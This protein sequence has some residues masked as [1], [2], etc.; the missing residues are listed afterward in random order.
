MLPLLNRPDPQVFCCF[1]RSVLGRQR[2]VRQCKEREKERYL[3]GD[4]RGAARGSRDPVRAR[5]NSRE[6]LQRPLIACRTL[7]KL[8]NLSESSFHICIVRGIPRACSVDQSTSIMLWHRVR[9]VWL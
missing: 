4:G 6:V 1:S 3:Q 5:W 9:T 7:A 8:I 2:Q